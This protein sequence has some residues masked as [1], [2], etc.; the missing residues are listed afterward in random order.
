[1]TCGYTHHHY[2]SGSPALNPV[3]LG[4]SKHLG[5]SIHNLKLFFWQINKLSCTLVDKIFIIVYNSWTVWTMLIWFDVCFDFEMTSIFMLNYKFIFLGCNCFFDIKCWCMSYVWVCVDL[6]E[7][8]R[9][10]NKV[11]EMNKIRVD[12]WCWSSSS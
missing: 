2:S 12:F 9:N 4:H 7:L 1:M 6:L 5:R 10:L 3:V 8:A 11:R